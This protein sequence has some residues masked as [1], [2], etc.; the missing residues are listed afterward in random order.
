MPEST[1]SPV[2]A[3]CGQER[4]SLQCLARRGEL[5]NVCQ[6]CYC[7]EEIRELAQAL[8]G[9]SPDLAVLAEGLTTLYQVVRA[10]A[11]AA[12]AEQLSAQPGSR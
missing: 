4:P 1:L 11:D 7:T 5:L 3:L 8:P 12:L 6:F 9:D 2:C 10:S